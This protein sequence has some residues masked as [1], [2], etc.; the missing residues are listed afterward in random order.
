[1]TT[2]NLHPI[3]SAQ[4]K[5]FRATQHKATQ[6]PGRSLMLCA[7]YSRVSITVGLRS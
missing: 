3:D 4:C 7:Y 6:K 2:K 5:D 1:M